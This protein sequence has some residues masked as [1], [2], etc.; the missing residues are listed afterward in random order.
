MAFEELARRPNL[1]V[2]TANGKPLK[3]TVTVE[4][5]DGQLFDGWTSVTVTKNLESVANGFSMTLHDRFFPLGQRW[6]L[7]PGVL[8]KINVA[9]ER[10][11]TGRIEKLDAS[12][13]EGTRT[14]SVSGRSRPGD[15]VD[16]SVTGSTEYTQ[17]ALDELARQLIA[18]F[19]LKVF[20]SVTPKKIEKFA[21]KPGETVFEALDRAARL[22]GF[23]WISTRGGNLRLTRAGR[24]RANSE[25]S[26]DV[27]IKGASISIDT[28]ERHNEYKVIGQNSGTDELFGKNA[29]QPFG[30]ALDSGITRHRPLTIV[31][32]STID[33]DK[34][35]TRAEWEA[36]NRV[37]NGMRINCV[38]ESWLQQDESLWDINQIVRLRAS[39]IGIDA[40]LLISSVEQK[41]D[42]T[43]GTTTTF[44]LVRKD[45]F[46][47]QPEFTEANDPLAFLGHAT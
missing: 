15:L 29:A 10:V 26:Q 14:L 31:A 21:V 18:P 2:P 5:G 32:E 19:G 45:S 42:N 8:V 41:Q 39:Y 37:A 44:G 33:I 40:D 36:A 46:D 28:S 6:P 23:F 1:T 43:G 13:S 17:I 35:T 38:T 16:A 3:Q 34:A 11:L 12:Y 20:L 9:K 30:S 22:Q 27:N 7:K 4:T 47:P 24:G 25:L